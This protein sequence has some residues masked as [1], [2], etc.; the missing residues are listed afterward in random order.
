MTNVKDRD[1]PDSRQRAVYKIKRSDCQAFYTAKTGRNLNTRLTEHKQ[2]SRNGDVN[3]HIAVHHRLT[4]T[5]LTAT[6]LSA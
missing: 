2:A 1:E 3:N 5:T 4:K 6:L